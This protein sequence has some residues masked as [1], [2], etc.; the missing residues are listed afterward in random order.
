MQSCPKA[1]WGHAGCA[2]LQDQH[3]SV[4]ADAAACK[5]SLD[6]LLLG[7]PHLQQIIGMY[8][9]I[10]VQRLSLPCAQYKHFA[11]CACE[12]VAGSAVVS[13]HPTWTN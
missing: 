10:T 13:C 6:G 12:V 4:F 7:L 5:A 1:H 2:P 8:S 11:N 3:S 9:D